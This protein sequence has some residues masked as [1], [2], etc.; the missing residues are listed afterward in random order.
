MTKTIERY[1]KVRADWLLANEASWH[2]SDRRMANQLKR[3]AAKR[4]R[5]ESGAAESSHHEGQIKP[6]ASRF[7]AGGE[8]SKERGLRTLFLGLFIL[9][10]VAIWVG[11]ALAIS[12]VAYGVDA[13]LRL[14]KGTVPTRTWWF[15]AA[16]A[17]AAIGVVIGLL[18]RPLITVATITYWPS[19]VLDVHWTSVGAIYLWLQVVLGLLLGAWQVRRHGW[20]GVTVTQAATIPDMPT[21]VAVPTV[22]EAP[23]VPALPVAAVETQSDGHDEGPAAPAVPAIPALPEIAELDDDDAQTA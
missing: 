2:L 14:K 23:T 13:E 15:V 20:P 9:P 4:E 1:E 19:I 5:G 6:I 18:Y 21:S 11:P 16:A 3:A 22:P 17:A 7:I 12:S 10:A 8:D